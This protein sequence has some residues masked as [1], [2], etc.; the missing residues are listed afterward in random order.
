MNPIYTAITFAPVQDFIS[1]SRKLR[2]LYGSSFLLSYLA[3]AVCEAAIDEHRRVISPALINVVQGTPNQ[4]I[5][6]GDFSKDEAQAAFHRAWKIVVH[7][8]RQWLEAQIAAEYCWY[9]EW[10]LWTNYAWEF[11]WAQGNSISEARRNLNQVKSSRNWTGINWMGESSTLSG[12]DAIAYPEMG[13]KIDPTKQDRQQ[14]D[15]IRQFYQQLRQL[16][17]LGQAFVDESEQLSIPELTKRLITYDAIA[18]QLNLKPNELPS[19]EIPGTFRDLNRFEDQRWT[20]WFQGDGDGIGIYLRSLADAGKDEAETL[21]QFSR[22]MLDWG[23]NALIPAVKRLGRVIY[24]GGDDFLGVFYHNPPEPELTACECLRWFYCFPEVWGKHG[25]DI[26]VSVGFVWA[27]GGIPQR[28]ILQH[29]QE[30]EQS[31]KRQGKDRLAIR[32]LF[33]GGNYLEWTCPWWFL[34]DVLQ[35]YRDRQ[36]GNNWTH[37]YSDVAALESRHAFVG[38][39]SEVALALFEIYFGKANRATLERYLGNYDG[40]SGILGNIKLKRP[41]NLNHWII[42][43]AKIGFHTLSNQQPEVR[44]SPTAELVSMP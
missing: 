25:Q 21:G 24:A 6:A 39:Q 3:R 1:K 7:T 20:G 15:R 41:D 43:L 30:A 37:I 5:I 32:V 10:Q 4:I 14:S 27:G 35:G 11:F 8:C 31:A 17:P 22:A 16:K 33:N 29:C 28:D 34:P 26:S 2:D 40:K 42:N 36:G 44:L 38:D 19:V 12:V 13:G 9:K 18:S 23:R